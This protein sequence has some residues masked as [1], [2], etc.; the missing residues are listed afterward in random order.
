MA[1]IE[2]TNGTPKSSIL[3]GFSIIKFIHF[4]GPPLFLGNTQLVK[5]YDTP[6]MKKKRRRMGEPRL[7]PVFIDVVPNRY[8]PSVEPSDVCD[9]KKRMDVTGNRKVV[10]G[11]FKIGRGSLFDKF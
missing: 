5:H 6:Q 8:V 9:G 7:T 11:P 4:G 10:W 3:I 1:Q 2:K